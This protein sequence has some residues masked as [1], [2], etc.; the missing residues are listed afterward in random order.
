MALGTGTIFIVAAVAVLFGSKKKKKKKKNGQKRIP[1]PPPEEP[2]YDEE[3]CGL[4]P[5]LPDDVDEVTWQLVDQGWDDLEEISIEVA[6]VVYEVTPEGSPQPWPPAAND[7][8][9]QCILDRIRIRVNLILAEKADQEA[10]GE[11]G[12]EDLPVPDYDDEQWAPYPDPGPVDIESV[13]HPENYP[14]PGTFHQVGG[15]NSAT[16]TKH[17]A[18]KALMQAHYSLFQDGE[19][20][21]A[22]ADDSENWRRYRD[23]MDCSPFND[24][25]LGARHKPGG[26]FWYDTPT[27][28]QI[29][30][31]PVHDALLSK[32]AYGETLERRVHID[33]PQQPPGGEQPA[34]WLPP[35]DEEALAEGRVELDPEYWETGDSKILP[36]P[37]VLVL[38]DPEL[39][40]IPPNQ[41]WGCMGYELQ[42]QPAKDFHQG[43]TQSGFHQEEVG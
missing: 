37:E 12:F 28:R 4:Y 36:P 2:P 16:T 6:G 8:R 7:A 38:V 23:L 34:I 24:A 17:I 31:M 33:N 18:Q 14:D 25:F 43:E 1:E 27:G 3:H 26:G 15:P 41:L 21:K 35:L 30:M 19:A 42:M 11:A 10:D 32:I 40:N 5:W 20:A 22:F 29:A 9:A 13:T 39:S